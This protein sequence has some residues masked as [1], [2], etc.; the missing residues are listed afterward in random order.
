MGAGSLSSLVIDLQVNSAAMRDGMAKAVDSLKQFEHASKEIGEGLKK[1]GELAVVEFGRRAVEGI[2][3]FI[4]KGAEAADHMGKLAQAAG[5]PVEK[6]SQLAYA[7]SLS[8]LSSEEVSV[9]FNK[10]NKDIA[11]AGAGV[12]KQAA[13]FQALGVKVKDAGG[14]VRPTDKIL[15]DLAERFA[16][17]ADSASKSQLAMEVFGQKAGA[18]LLP[19]LNRG[20]EGI[21]ELTAEADR[22]GVTLSGEAVA[23]ATE[24]SDNLIRM[25]A[26]SSAFAMHVAGE[27]SPALKALTDEMLKG[28]QTSTVF[29]DGVKFVAGAI[30][31]LTTVAIEAVAGFEG[32]ALTIKGVALAMGS[33]ASGDLKGA[34]DRIKQMFSD[35]EKSSKQAADRV[36]AV[37]AEPTKALEEHA[38]HGKKDAAVVEAN[39]KRMEKAAADYKEALKSLTKM[40]DEMQAKNEAIGQGPDAELINRITGGDL[41]KEFAKLGT[42]IGDALRERVLKLIDDSRAKLDAMAKSASDFALGRSSAA[43]DRSS[44]QARAAFGEIGGANADHTAFAAFQRL[45]EGFANF[46]AALDIY[47][48]ASKTQAAALADA[49][50]AAKD[51]DLALERENIALADRMEVLKEKAGKAAT[52]FTDSAKTHADAARE[53]AKVMAEA[54]QAYLDKVESM[55]EGAAASLASKLGT[56]GNVINGALEG[57]KSGG[58]IGAIIGV[59]VAII[60]KF[61]GFAVIMDGINGYLGKIIGAL[62]SGVSAVLDSIQTL[63]DLSNAITPLIPILRIVSNALTLAVITFEGVIMGIEQLWAW[64]QNIFDKKAAA[65]TQHNVDAMHDKMTAQLKSLQDPF[66]STNNRTAGD[67][68]DAHDQK[69][70][71]PPAGTGISDGLTSDFTK[72]V[73]AMAGAATKAADQLVK[74]N[75]SLTNVPAGF[76]TA[77]RRFEATQQPKSKDEQV[78]GA[79]ARHGTKNG[80]VTV[81]VSGGV[82]VTVK[83]LADAVTKAISQNTF[84]RKGTQFGR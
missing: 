10:L 84:Q 71:T 73:G 54:S 43:T 34:G 2:A 48:E 62:D 40:A 47:T 28:E 72:G 36:A 83:D 23:A 17:M 45:T 1:L 49:A 19:F 14:A 50:L 18:A 26:V 51:G 63:A 39:F 35:M 55:I 7:M 42:T 6:F 69:P 12:E 15:G 59:I 41:A 64:I 74:I 29:G 82:M 53:A 75:E 46:G 13:L 56:A 8:G 60:D 38:E 78:A 70:E 5:L 52:A 37:W 76:K 30:K 68:V 9:A 77:L 33:L 32:F 24:F 31:V 11:L 67:L 16:G 57:F 4:A 21:A 80:S 3:E 81:N 66:D 27:L 65:E 20:K 22:L 44:G 25:K 61:K 79:D 58:I